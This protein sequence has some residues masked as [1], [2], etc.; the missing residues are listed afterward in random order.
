[1]IL[2]ENWHPCINKL[3]IITKHPYRIT[4]TLI[5]NFRVYS[6]YLANLFDGNGR[7]VITLCFP[8]K[9]YR[10]ISTNIYN[11]HTCSSGRFKCR[12]ISYDNK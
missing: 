12:P 9:S 2:P 7:I 11:K 6:T 3:V 8:L 1:M 4:C 5:E 10:I